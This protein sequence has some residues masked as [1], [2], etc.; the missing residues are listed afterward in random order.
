MVMVLEFPGES[1]GTDFTSRRGPTPGSI[2]RDDGLF[3]IQSN[4]NLQLSK[5]KR[6]L[7]DFSE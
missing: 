6:S 2:P 7:K 3:G 1:T 4:P 5:T